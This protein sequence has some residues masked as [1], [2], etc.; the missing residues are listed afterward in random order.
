LWNWI[1]AR[2]LA[3]KNLV[4]EFESTVQA[5]DSFAVISYL[6]EQLQKHQPYNDERAIAEAQ[7]EL[8]LIFTFVRDLVKKNSVLHPQLK[9]FFST[10]FLQFAPLTKTTSS[11]QEGDKNKE[12]QTEKEKE[13]KEKEVEKKNL[14]QEQE[15][16]PDQPTPSTEIKPKKRRANLCASDVMLTLVGVV[17]EVAKSDF[18]WKGPSALTT[19]DNRL[20]TIATSEALFGHPALRDSSNSIPLLFHLVDELFF[21]VF[22]IK[23]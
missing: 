7:K 3:I 9:R 20:R 23:E 8:Q 13:E 6:Y 11:G 5:T 17:F 2:T 12:P 15:K 18:A 21:H 16:P 1:K 19:G 10:T 14:E 4:I 22:E